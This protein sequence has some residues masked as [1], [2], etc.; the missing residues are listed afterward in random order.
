M[1]VGVLHVKPIKFPVSHH[2]NQC[3]VQKQKHKDFP[4]ALSYVARYI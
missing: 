4:A 2:K 3:C 1:S